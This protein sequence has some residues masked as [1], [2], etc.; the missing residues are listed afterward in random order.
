M[1]TAVKVFRGFKLLC[2]KIQNEKTKLT[3]YNIRFTKPIKKTVNTTKSSGQKWKKSLKMMVKMKNV[4]D[5]K[6]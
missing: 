5:T 3:I 2:F 1:M 4:V 6:I